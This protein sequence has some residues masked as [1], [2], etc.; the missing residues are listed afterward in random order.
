MSISRGMQR[1]KLVWA[2]ACVAVAAFL[3]FM[4]AQGSDSGS[5]GRNFFGV[6]I[7][8]AALAG[9][10][11]VSLPTD[12]KICLCIVGFF[13]GLS[14]ADGPGKWP[15]GAIIAVVFAVFLYGVIW[16]VKGF[17]TRQGKS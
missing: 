3:L 15:E 17:F 6:L 5:I 10:P 14:Y 1:L 11:F 7:A 12:A 4:L 9:L 13:G 16:V 2:V 8:T